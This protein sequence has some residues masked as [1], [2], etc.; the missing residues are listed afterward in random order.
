MK[1]TSYLFGFYLLPFL[2]VL[3]VL[4]VPTP[5]VQ[6]AR[7]SGGTATY[8]AL[9]RRTTP[10]FPDQPPSCPICAKVSVVQILG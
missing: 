1:A 6:L 7:E 5:T 9:Q 10:F 4:G 3:S 8:S 2:L